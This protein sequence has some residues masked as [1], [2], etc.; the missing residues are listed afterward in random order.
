MSTVTAKLAHE[1]RTELD[2]MARVAAR[3]QT[4][5][6]RNRVS[7]D[8]LYLDSVALNLHGFYDGLERVFRRI[9]VVADNEMPEGANWHQLLL[10]QMAADRPPVRPA[11]ISDATRDRLW[12]FC[13]FRHVARHVYAFNFAP[14]RLAPLL[15]ALP[16]LIENLSKELLAFADFVEAPA[17][18][19]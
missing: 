19:R 9:A 8:D 2:N 13:G 18:D 17:A 1:I 5:W 11:V 3:A 16:S 10:Q 12:E 15:A 6:E 7:G 4:A 14:D